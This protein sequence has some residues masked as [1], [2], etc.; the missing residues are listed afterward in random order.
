MPALSRPQKIT[1]G[2]MR[3][4]GVRGILI[5]CADYT[6]SHSIAI[7]GD[8]W[9]DHVRLSD[10]E[11]R[12]VCRACGQRG[13]DIR[14]DFDWN[15]KAR[16]HDGLPAVAR[17]KTEREKP[18]KGAKTRIDCTNEDHGPA[19]CFR[20]GRMH[21]QSAERRNEP[22]CSRPIRPAHSRCAGI[23][24]RS[25]IASTKPP[26]RSGGDGFRPCTRDPPERRSQ[27]S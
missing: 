2:E 19:V 12:F 6:C 1:F 16:R 24:N 18:D 20:V 21:G 3:S 25:R 9:P 5:Y 22:S 27:R 10:L 8:R 17:L 23:A 11:S 13:T 4:S 15:K 26:P 14:P 7:S